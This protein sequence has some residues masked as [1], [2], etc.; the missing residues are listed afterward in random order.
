MTKKHYEL[1]AEM[2]GVPLSQAKAAVSKTILEL[3][4][5][6]YILKF[7]EWLLMNNLTSKKY[8]GLRDKLYLK[9]PLNITGYHLCLMLDPDIF[10]KANL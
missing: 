5:L 7:K 8:L 3:Q 2:Y 9:H 6:M 4:K 1:Y 10:F